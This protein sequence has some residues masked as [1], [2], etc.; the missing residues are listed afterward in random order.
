MTSAGS[1]RGL[2]VGGGAQTHLSC[3]PGVWGRVHTVWGR[4]CNEDAP[5]L[6]LVLDEEFMWFELQCGLMLENSLILFYKTSLEKT[7]I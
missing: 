7:M 4:R 1:S 5:G 3:T 2:G 6:V